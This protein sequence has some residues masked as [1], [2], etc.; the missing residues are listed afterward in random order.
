MWLVLA[1]VR[2]RADTV[3]AELAVE[4]RRLDSFKVW[5]FHIQSDLD[6]SIHHK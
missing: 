2:A 6:M 1:C 3:E 4:L 5:P